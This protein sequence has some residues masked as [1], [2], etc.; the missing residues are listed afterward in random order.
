MQG[1]YILS[2]SPPLTGEAFN[3]LD[4]PLMRVTGADVP[5]PYATSL[6]KLALPRKENVVATACQLLNIS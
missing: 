5:M 6:E 2:V 4:G 3:Y 1:K